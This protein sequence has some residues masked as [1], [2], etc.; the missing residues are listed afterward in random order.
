VSADAGGHVQGIG[1]S[2]ARPPLMGG[3]H[4]HVILDGVVSLEGL[5]QDLQ[6]MAA[7]LRQFIQ[8]ETPVVRPR[9]LARQRHLAAPD[10]PHSEMV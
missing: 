8:K 5:A 6:D 2:D 4:R 9:R 1:E 10:Q 3:G 7:G